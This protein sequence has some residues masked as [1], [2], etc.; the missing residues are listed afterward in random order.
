[1][2]QHGVDER[3]HCGGGTDAEGERENSH[4]GEAGIA[5]QRAE[6][7][8]NVAAELVE[9]AE[10]DSGSV[11]LVLGYGLA[12]V[13]AGFAA[14]FLG[15]EALMDEVFLIGREVRAEFF[16]DIVGAAG[17]DGSP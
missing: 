12:K 11:S 3:E 13:D 8:A 4:S 16:F 5:A 14:S 9:D 2:Q 1:M 15:S 7:V 10:A 6:A 17:R